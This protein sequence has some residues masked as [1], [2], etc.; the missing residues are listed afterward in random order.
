MQNKPDYEVRITY[1]AEHGYTLDEEYY[2]G[3]ITT[4]YL[5]KAKQEAMKMVKSF[6]KANPNNLF[7]EA[8]RF[9]LK[10]CRPR[11]QSIVTRSAMWERHYQTD[12]KL[13]CAGVGCYINIKAI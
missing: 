9:N 8:M 3:E 13:R 5:K 2:L 10:Y 11:W 6:V 7:S 4:F 1:I 12:K